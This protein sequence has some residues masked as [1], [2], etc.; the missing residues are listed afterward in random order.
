MSSLQGRWLWLSAFILMSASALAANQ[1]RGE[2]TVNGRIIASACAIE[3]ASRDQTINMGASPIG[4]IIRDGQGEKRDFSI[5]LVNCALEKF[6]PELADWRY[7]Q[8]T[9]DGRE[10]GGLFAIDG[11]AKGIALKITD[12]FGN[13]AAPGVPVEQ[14][15]IQPGAMTMN[16]GLRVVGNNQLMKAGDYSSTV[17]FKMDYY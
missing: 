17:R 11:D 7:F 3:T 15:A 4:Q 2:V 9:F 5:Q 1:G 6:N 16:Y 12:D 14:Y 8:V 13:V 10:D